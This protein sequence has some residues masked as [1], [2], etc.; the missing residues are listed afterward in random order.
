MNERK[1][2]YLESILRVQLDRLEVL[3]VFGLK[4]HVADDGSLLVALEWIA[5]KNDSLQNDLQR[6]WRHHDAGGDCDVN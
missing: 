5:C 4:E 6:V 3:D 2:T 1:G